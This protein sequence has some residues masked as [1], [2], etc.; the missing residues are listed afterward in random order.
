MNKSFCTSLLALTA[1]GGCVVGPAYQPP[2]TPVPARW[3]AVE[4]PAPAGETL[5][6]FWQ[7]FDDPVLLRLIAQSIGGNLDLQM[8]GQRLR[9]AQDMARVAASGAL[10]QI[11]LGAAAEA[12]R[13]SQTLDWPPASPSFGEYPFYSIGFNASWELD[14][15]G[16]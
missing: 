7:G 6:G 1:L 14:L 11:G 16:E 15:F 12:Q 10:P 4:A 13:Q 5:G 9:I 2:Q 3:S 8:A